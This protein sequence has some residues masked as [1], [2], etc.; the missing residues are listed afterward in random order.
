LNERPTTRAS[1][2][3][4]QEDLDAWAKEIERIRLLR[5]EQAIQLRNNKKARN[6]IRKSLKDSKLQLHQLE[7]QKKP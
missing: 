3:S 4:K 2:T 5:D 7:K 1:T 6:D